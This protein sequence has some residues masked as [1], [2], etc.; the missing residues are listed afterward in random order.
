MVKMSLT[1][2]AFICIFNI[3]PLFVIGISKPIQA[4]TP[5]SSSDSLLHNA[6]PPLKPTSQRSILPENKAY[7]LDTGDVIQVTVFGLPDQ[8]GV[9]QVFND[10]TVTFPLIGTVNVRGKTI[11]E[12]NDL[13]TSL[14]SRYLKRPSITVI[15]QQPRPLEVAIVGEVN[16]PGNYNLSGGTQIQQ[17]EGQTQI[18]SNT[19]SLP[20]V[21]D[22]FTLAGGLTVSADVRQ[23][24]LK[25]QEKGKEVLYVLDFW[26]LLQEGDLAQD[27]R[28]KDGDVIVVPKK[29]VIDPNE[30]RQLAD[31]TFG[32]KYIEPPNV[33]IVGEVNRPGSY[34]VP[35]E[36]GP[37]RL[38]TAI[39]QSGGIREL[40]DIRNIVISRTTRDAQQQKIEVN[41]WELLES[42]DINRDVLLR[43]GDTI[44]IPTAK[45][46]EPSE[47]Q[48]LASANFAPNEIVVNVVGSVRNPGSTVLKPNTSLN[49]AI[50]AA[51]GFDERR[52]DSSTV[53][54]IRVN[55]N[56]TVT[57]R[58][59]PVNLAAE[60]NE[61][62][63]P[64][65]QNNDVIVINR[66]AIAAFG[67][68][69]ESV[70]GPI[71]R[72]FSLLGFFNIFQ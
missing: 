12:V 58:N 34:T 68:S 19:P 63:N 39:Q 36:Q 16:V 60:V 70:L 37:P 72:S 6:L 71:G 13:L 69:V 47:A 59:I 49:N 32:I 2:I 14:Y 4:Q 7:T 55:P 8:G 67:D 45:E 9:V 3:S 53:E 65:L 15:L 22:L 43:D 20:K 24:Q 40:A 57:K 66:S 54:L 1:K 48:R 52:A 51:G 35:I 28:L 17:K 11:M 18:A 64:I 23:I 61:Q 10:G 41:L 56:G 38:T 44:F 62:T 33:T 29:D 42:G 30:Y 50:L 31:A 21:S 46:L 25:R 27:V 5:S 26:Q